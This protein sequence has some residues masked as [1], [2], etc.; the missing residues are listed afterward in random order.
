MHT[1]IYDEPFADSSSIPTYF[2]N[3]TVHELGYRVLL[4]G[5]G[6]DEFWLGYNRYI[7][8]LIIK[9]LHNLPLLKN[10]L[11]KSIDNVFFQKLIYLLFSKR[12]DL[13]QFAYRLSQMKKILKTNNIYEYYE[14][15]ITQGNNKSII[16][17]RT[18]TY[19][20]FESKDI[21]EQMSLTD[22]KYYM[23]G[24]I[25]VK[26]DRASMANSVETRSPFVD[27]DLVKYALSINNN[28]KIVKKKTKYPLRMLLREIYPNYDFDMPKK[29]FGIPLFDWL[30][31]D[32]I[33]SEVVS[34]ISILYE[35]DIFNKKYVK[36]V[37]NEFYQYSKPNAYQVWNL[38]LLAQFLEKNNLKF[39][40]LR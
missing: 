10:V 34:T 14:F 21:L 7:H 16:D 39:I 38:Y 35:Y 32:Y 19:S 31:I 15:L 4:T 28:F 36:Q 20:L 23:Q 5:N 40:N 8:A 13:R 1:D 30:K 25:F 3:K 29:G 11:Y 22:A 17:F 18:K 37:L 26:N 27:I 9:K 33:K 24:D 2:L 6:G 12:Y